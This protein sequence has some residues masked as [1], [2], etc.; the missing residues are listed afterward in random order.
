MA[1][2]KHS[3]KRNVGLTYE[4]L[5]R[6]M[7]DATIVGDAQLCDRIGDL[8]EARFAPGTELVRELRIFN[9]LIATH[10]SSDAAASRIVEEARKA[11]KRIDASRLSA[12]KTNLIDA[13]ARLGVQDIYEHRIPS[14]RTYAVLQGLFDGWRSRDPDIGA[15]ARFENDLIESLRL[16]IVVNE[17]TDDMA[18]DPLIERMMVERINTRYA[19]S[20]THTQM[21]IVREAA[22]HGENAQA[23]MAM[24]EDVR[25]SAYEGLRKMVA[26]PPDDIPESVLVKA[27]DALDAIK[28]LGEVVSKESI[29]DDVIIARH[30]V[31]AGLID[32]LS[33]SE[34]E[35]AL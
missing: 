7:A 3:K 10:V 31:I 19:S 13:I 14:Y 23:V 26:V 16:P 1:S 30:M 2:V 12:E 6:A 33:A 28:L 11:V 4:F 25:K 22:L 8:V 32:E 34:A 27:R 29:I 18:C 9:A 21:H 35:G 15:M 20:L 24:L 5:I 17:S